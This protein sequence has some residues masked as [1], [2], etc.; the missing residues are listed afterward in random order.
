ML[1]KKL[2][3][4]IKENKTIS[5]S[6]YME[7][8]LFDK[9]YGFYEN[10]NIFGKEGHFITS[11]LISKYFSHCIA[12]NFISVCEQEKIDNIVEFGAGNAK[13]ALDLI[14]HLKDKKCLPQKYYFFE[15]S[16]KLID[17]Q[18]EIINNLNLNEFLDFIWIKEFKELPSQAFIIANEFFDCIPT[19]LFR[20]RGNYYQRA[21]IN[22]N[23]ELSWEKRDFLS[24]VSSNYLSLPHNLLNNYMFEFSIGQYDILNNISKFIDK[25]YFLILD[26]GYSANEL[27]IDDRMEGTLTCIRNHLSDFNPVDEIGKKDLSSFV[28][29]SYLKNIL[30][31]NEWCT[32]AFMSQAN[33]LLSFNILDSVDYRDVKELASIKKLILPNHMGELFKV[34]IADKNLNKISNRFI[35]NDIMKL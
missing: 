23:L 2:K 11:P 25:A 22:D 6:E 3:S 14:L 32:N 16:S 8:V 28:N 19:D 26:Y 5:F 31:S 10:K 15:K 1:K 27:Y 30:D 21:C 9:E 12:K 13:L 20:K 7:I 24:E 35:K 4:K 33:Y 34:L 18:K 17:T 29:F